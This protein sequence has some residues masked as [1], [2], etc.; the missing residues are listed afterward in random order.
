MGRAHRSSR[1]IVHM[2][3]LVFVIASSHPKCDFADEAF[4]MPVK[5][6]FAF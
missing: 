6:T 2:D 5:A 1:N 3:K 4:S